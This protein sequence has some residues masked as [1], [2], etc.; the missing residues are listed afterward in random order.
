MRIPC[1]YCG[2]RDVAEFTYLG[3]ATL[4]RPEPGEDP[5]RTPP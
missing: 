4:Q 1:P 5:P 2:S 3:D